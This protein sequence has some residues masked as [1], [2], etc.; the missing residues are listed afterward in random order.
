MSNEDIARYADSLRLILYHK[1]PTSARTRYLKLDGNS[2]CAF[3][4]L[5]AAAEILQS[6]AGVTES[7]ILPHPA[8]VIAAAEHWLGLA[9]GALEYQ[10]DFRAVVRAGKSDYRIFLVRFT[11]ID[12]PFDAAQRVGADFIAITE[13]RSL[14]PVELELLRQAY[15][16]VMEG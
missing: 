7:G 11:D 2:V 3:H 13:A 1:H 4:P 15:V 8:A 14:P 10:S 9:P 5:P 16:H 6:Q 12:P